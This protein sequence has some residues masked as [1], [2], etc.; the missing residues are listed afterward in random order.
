MRKSSHQGPADPR[1]TPE[2]C[3]L[4]AMSVRPLNDD[5]LAKLP[6]S[7]NSTY[8][9]NSFLRCQCGEVGTSRSISSHRAHAGQAG[10]HLL[11]DRDPDVFMSL[12]DAMLY[13]AELSAD[14][15]RARHEEEEQLR[16]AWLVAHPQP[17]VIKRPRGRPRKVAVERDDEGDEMEQEQPNRIERSQGRGGG[18]TERVERPKQL[19]SRMTLDIPVDVLERC[20]QVRLDP[21]YG[22]SGD[23]TD[24]LVGIERDFWKIVDWLAEGQS[25]PLSALSMAA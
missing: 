18:G 1:P 24:Y 3:I 14:Q 25:T 13:E 17:V 21:E 4:A 11:C 7:S 5:E 22:F 6:Y 9:R 10:K 23:V 16:Q 15:K 12:D 19:T 8:P 20:N 2:G